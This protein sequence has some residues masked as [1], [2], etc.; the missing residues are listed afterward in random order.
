MEAFIHTGHVVPIQS[1]KLEQRDLQLVPLVQKSFA[2][3]LRTLV[4]GCDL[5][6]YAIRQCIHHLGTKNDGQRLQKA[7]LD[8]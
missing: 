7:L 4:F 1:M 5:F 8:R 6:D 2:L 3:K